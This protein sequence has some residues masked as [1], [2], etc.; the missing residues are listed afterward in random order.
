MN[1]ETIIISMARDRGFTENLEKLH[2]IVPSSILDLDE[3]V[4]TNPFIDYILENDSIR[5]DLYEFLYRSDFLQLLD[6]DVIEY[7]KELYDRNAP[8]EWYYMFLTVFEEKDDKEEFCKTIIDAFRKNI[9]IRDTLVMFEA[10]KTA[11]EMK[12]NIEIFLQVNRGKNGDSGAADESARYEIERYEQI[13][14]QLNGT[15]AAQ[16]QKIEDIEMEKDR[17]AER[18]ADFFDKIETA[19]KTVLE[20]KKEILMY[21]SD[22]EKIINYKKENSKIISTTRETLERYVNRIHS[23]E[24]MV[25]EVND[26]LSEANASLD[27]QRVHIDELNEL[28]EKLRSE[29]EHYSALSEQY[30]QQLINLA[31]KELEDSESD[32]GE[33]DT[34]EFEASASDD[35]VSRLDEVDFISEE[36]GQ[37]SVSEETEQGEDGYDENADYGYEDVYDLKDNS[38]EFF[39]KSNIFIDFMLKHSE[40]Y[41]NKRPRQEQENLIKIKMMDMLFS[42][43]KVKIVKENLDET[44]PCY[45]LYKL[46]SKNPS[47]DELREFFT[48]YGL[49]AVAE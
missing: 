48:D 7:C 27:E 1:N 42:L 29:G 6:K 5:R 25:A 28:V 23:L 15:I 47:D 10:N 12:N 39:K 17:L 34:E 41:F 31:S 45:E 40:K 49:G 22:R 43:D 21:R 9:S 16:K 4:K 32:R 36:D 33:K 3:N 44:I 11:S 30:H 38:E 24:N 19:N 20:I 26:E 8:I 13:I 46:I 18:N 2:L 14:E 37:I 35:S